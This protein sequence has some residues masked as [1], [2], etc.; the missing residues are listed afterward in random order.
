MLKIIKRLLKPKNLLLSIFVKFPFIISD[1]AFIKYRYKL[2]MGRNLDLENPQS[3]NEKLQW[4]KL[5]NRMPEYTKMVDKYEVKLHVANTIGDDYI[6]PTLGVWKK[7]EDIDFDILPDHFVLKTTHD[8][9]GVFICKDQAT[10]DINM[11]KQKIEK[12]LQ[13]NYFAF[14]R[15]WPYKN[16]EPK[17]IAEQLMI[18]ESGSGLK[19]Y[20]FFCFD[21]IPKVVKIASERGNDTRFDYFDMDFNHLP[22]THMHKN[23]DEKIYKPYN[24]KLMIELSKNLS[25]GLPHVRVDLYN[26]NGRIYFGE[27]TF[28]HWDGMVPFVP[29]EWDYK[30]GEWISLPSF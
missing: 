11:V 16:V 3:F 9:G 25:K 21:G 12:R 23:S 13:R 1:K 14:S 8:S 17:I 26:I 22:F 4:L 19:D 24:F 2:L 27:L 7:F 6:I 20:K 28:F 5:Y 18:D 30:F 15:E 10:L 29:E